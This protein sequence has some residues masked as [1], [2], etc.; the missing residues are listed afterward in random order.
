MAL[1]AAS[2]RVGYSADNVTSWKTAGETAGDSFELKGLIN[3]TKLL[4]RA[5]AVNRDRQS[6]PANEYPIYVTAQPPLPPDGLKTDLTANHVRLAWGEVLGVTE[7]RLYRRTPGQSEF[8][9]IFRGRV[10]EFMDRTAT[11]SPAFAS[12]GQAANLQRP[13]GLIDEYAVTAVTGNGESAKFLVTFVC[14][15][16]VVTVLVSDT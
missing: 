16:E 14:E 12:P 2:F 5:I 8:T 13:G 10:N 4:I 9:E 1:R 6:R 7:Y 15:D 3:N 11:S